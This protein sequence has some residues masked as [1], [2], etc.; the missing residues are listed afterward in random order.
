[1]VIHLKTS[2]CCENLYPNFPNDAKMEKVSD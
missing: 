2:F 1:M